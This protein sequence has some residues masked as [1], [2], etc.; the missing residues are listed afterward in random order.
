MP[1]VP[2]GSPVP[3]YFAKI[4]S[5]PPTKPTEVWIELPYPIDYK[6][7]IYMARILHLDL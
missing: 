7:F 1:K 6:N 4:V 3:R 5:N 2:P